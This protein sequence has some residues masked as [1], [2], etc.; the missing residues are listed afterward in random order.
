MREDESLA[1]RDFGRWASVRGKE[2]TGVAVSNQGQVLHTVKKTGRFNDPDPVYRDDEAISNSGLSKLAK[3]AAWFQYCRRNPQGPTEALVRGIATHAAIFESLKFQNTYVQRPKFDR[4]FAKGKADAHQWELENQ[5]KIALSQEDWDL[6]IGM[7]DAVL[8]HRVARQILAEGEAEQS[9]YWQSEY[10]H[11]RCKARAD[12]LSR[13]WLV[14]L[15][16]TQSASMDAFST[17]IAKYRYHVQLAYYLDGLA[18][19]GEAKDHAMIIAVESE[20]PHHVAIYAPDTDMLETGRQI[21]K[22]DLAVYAKCL[23]ED[24]WPGLP[25]HVQTI[26][27]PSWAKGAA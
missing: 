22:R 2:L 8:N 17:S 20:P 9:I 4:R 26:S 6:V 7:R 24:R 11:V 18:A 14:D 1:W 21:Y 27:L 19:I 16:T 3:S 12:W 25:E 13:D 10:P 15:K 5:G 23:L